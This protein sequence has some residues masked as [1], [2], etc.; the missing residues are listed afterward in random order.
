MS[1]KEYAQNFAMAIPV[2]AATCYGL[3]CFMEYVA[4]VVTA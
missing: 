2:L 3:L 1:P 4:R